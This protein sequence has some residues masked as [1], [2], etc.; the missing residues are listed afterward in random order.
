MLKNSKKII[1]KT[2]GKK[3]RQTHTTFFLGN[4]QTRLEVGGKE[5]G[6]GAA[7][8]TQTDGINGQRAGLSLS[9]PSSLL[10]QRFDGVARPHIRQI[11]QT[12]TQSRSQR[13]GW[14]TVARAG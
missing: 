9:K 6:E 5:R 1:T 11:S 8:G 14:V 10:S 7:L 13:L 4:F 3:R 12:R 2:K